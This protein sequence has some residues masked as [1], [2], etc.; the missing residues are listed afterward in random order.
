MLARQWTGAEWVA[1]PAVLLL[2]ALAILWR[3][4]GK[5]AAPV[6]HAT[7]LDPAFSA[8]K[9]GETFPAEVMVG[10]ISPEGGG[11]PG[12]SLSLCF[13]DSG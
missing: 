5:D 4:S 6:F 8:D 3:N 9:G 13:T 7:F 1:E 11:C 12:I 2:S 10:S